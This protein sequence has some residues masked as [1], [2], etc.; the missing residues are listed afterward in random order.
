MNIKPLI[1]L[2]TVISLNISLFEYATNSSTFSYY[3]NAVKS[4][5]TNKAVEVSVNDIAIQQS[6]SNSNKQIVT[7]LVNEKNM[8]DSVVSA[9]D[10]TLTTQ[11]GLTGVREIINTVSWQ[12]LEVGNL[13]PSQQRGGAISF[14]IPKSDHYIF[15]IT[16][17]YQT[18]HYVIPSEEALFIPFVINPIS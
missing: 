14:E 6:I 2:L 1:V 11:D 13:S 17:G 10:Y 9:A 15:T 12:P 7:L 8:G 5:I 16:R 18:T 4:A 3:V